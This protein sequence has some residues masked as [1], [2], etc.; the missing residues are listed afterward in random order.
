MTI[1]VKYQLLP[2]YNVHYL[3]KQKHGQG[4]VTIVFA[5]VMCMIVFTVWAGL[6]TRAMPGPAPIPN[7]GH[8]HVGSGRE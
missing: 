8:L 2:L 7:S 4:R 1:V 3:M 5:N 6:I